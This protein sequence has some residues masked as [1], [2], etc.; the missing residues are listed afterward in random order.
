[1]TLTGL[2]MVSMAPM[3]SSPC[4]P[5][6]FRSVITTSSDSSWLTASSATT[7]SLKNRKVRRPCSDV[8]PETQSEQRLHVL[9]VVDDEQ[10][11]GPARIR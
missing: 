9:L 11:N 7:G 10:L 6:M 2:S 5:G 8:A 3:R 1:M 4:K